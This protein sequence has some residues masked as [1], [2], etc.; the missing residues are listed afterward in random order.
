VTRHW[1]AGVLVFVALGAAPGRVLA[2]G[3]APEKAAEAA[4]RSWLA[5]VDSGKYGESWDAAAAFF[6][7]SLTRAQWIDA[8]TKARSPLGRLG[9]R[10]LRGAKHETRLPGAPAGEYVVIEYD[11]SFATV[12]AATERVTPMQDPDGAWRVSG[13]FVLPAK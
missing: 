10:R 4:A 7:K 12:A 2:S 1:I 5:L 13:Y 3:E 11:T 9:S 8:V 6:Q